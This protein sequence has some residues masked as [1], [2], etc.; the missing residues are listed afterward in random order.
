MPAR[1]VRPRAEVL[2]AARAEAARAARPS[3]PCD[4]DAIVRTEPD[5]AAHDA[6]DH[7]VPGHDRRGDERQIALDDV[8]VCATESAR[9]DADEDLAGS[10][11]AYR[12]ILANERR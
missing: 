12:T 10:G 2:P 5:P 6:A 9:A 7:L 8:K 4:A 3:E 1:E 11:R